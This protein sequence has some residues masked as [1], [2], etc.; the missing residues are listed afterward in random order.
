MK[1]KSN[2]LKHWRTVKFYIKAKYELSEAELELILF[3]SSEGYFTKDVFLDYDRIMSWDRNRFC[4]LIK[5]GWID[6]FRKK[7]QREKPLY[8]ISRKAEK[9]VTTL[10]NILDGKDLEFK[11]VDQTVYKSEVSFTDKF[12]QRMLAKMKDDYS[13][14]RLDKEFKI[15]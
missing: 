9:M 12:Y 5:E 2:Y 3:L 8:Q 14:K 15:L 4:K 13:R 7:V 11:T 6:I 1:S 10:Y